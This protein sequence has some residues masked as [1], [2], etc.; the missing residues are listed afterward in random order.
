MVDEEDSIT[1]MVKEML[2]S[3]GYRV[4]TYETG[5]DALEALRNDPDKYDLLIADLTMP[6]VDRVRVA[7]GSADTETRIT[8]DTDD[9]VQ[10]QKSRAAASTTGCS[11]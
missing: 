8:Y 7:A 9:G 11:P 6:P 3:K 4:C 1:D 10:R 2:L 5:T